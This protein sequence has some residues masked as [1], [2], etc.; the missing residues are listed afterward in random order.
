[1]S[2]DPYAPCPC[3]SGKKLKFCCADLATDIEKIHRMIEGDQP[4]AALR[5]V[6]QTLIRDSERASLLDLKAVIEISLDEIESAAATV[7]RFLTAHPDSPT[8]LAVQAILLAKT[9]GGR[10]AVMPLQNAISKLDRDMPRR[11][12][13]AIGTVGHSLLVEG[14]VVAAQAHLW[15]HS[16]IAREQDTRALELLVRLNQD[17]G[18]PLLLRDRLQLRH[19]PADVAWRDEAD[20]AAQLADNGR[21]YEATAIIDGLGQQYGADPA[22][23]FNRALLGGWL[24]DDRALVAGLHAFARLDVPHDDAVEAEAVAQLLDTNVTDPQIDVVKLMY[25]VHDL[26]PLETRLTED[27]RT[28]AYDAEIYD[29]VETDGPKP[30]LSY[31]LLD[32]TEPESAAEITRDQVPAVLGMLSL[33]GRRTDRAERLELV[34]DRGSHFDAAVGILSEI[35]GPALGERVGEEVVGHSTEVEQALSWRW[36]FPVGTS[37]ARRRELLTAERRDAIV[38]RWPD[39]PRAVLSGKTPRQAKDDPALAIPLGALVLILEQGSNNF[40]QAD[41]IAELR[42]QLGLSNPEPIASDEVDVRKLPLV[43]AARVDL[44]AVSDDDLVHFYRHAMIA[45]A[46]A[47]ILAASREAIRRPSVAQRIPPDEA[48]RRL[49][50]RETDSSRALEQIAEA[51]RRSEEVGESTAEWDLTELEIHLSDANAEEAKRMLVEIEERHRNDPE[52]ATAVYRMLYEAGVIPP[53]NLTDEPTIPDAAE[54][55]PAGPVAVEESPIWTPG[56]DIA[57]AG[58]RKSKLWTPS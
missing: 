16:T 3:G 54:L 37:P 22:L 30:R 58:G 20:R 40:D 35:C 15:L 21:W 24:A 47:A 34:V 46:T 2:I 19:W 27:G 23:V 50:H 48:Y 32:R 6:E 36:H 56:S 5:H 31:L 29:Y 51:R 25:D 43:R 52:V 13:E 9:D 45:N 39:V 42:R 38:N 44:S 10:A 49:I 11:V 17:A 1:M 57:A 8:A 28:E 14:H 12:L 33:F 41:A 4:H 53:E 18:L 26:D 7:D 55:E